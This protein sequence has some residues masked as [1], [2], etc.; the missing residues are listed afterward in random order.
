[1]RGLLK[2][3]FGRL[4]KSVIFYILLAVTFFGS[5]YSEYET[6]SDP[7]CTCVEH[8]AGDFWFLILMFVSIMVPMFVCTDFSCGMIRNKITVG[9]SRAKVYASSLITSVTST[10]LIVAAWFLGYYPIGVAHFGFNNDNWP[11]ADLVLG[12]MGFVV[13]I[14]AFTAGIHFVCTLVTK[15]ALVIVMSIL[16]VL[17][18]TTFFQPMVLIYGY[19]NETVTVIK[20]EEETEEGLVVTYTEEENPYYFEDGT[21]MKTAARAVDTFFVP[22]QIVMLSSMQKDRTSVFVGYDIVVT[23]IIVA[24]GNAVFARKNMK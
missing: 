24:V 19:S 14:I 6:W 4:F 17:L 13:M 15:K 22:G 23:I 12:Y 1:M 7:E 20:N 3:D 10:L 21:P 11:V 2:S 18:Y 9:Y 5:M 16:F 8:R